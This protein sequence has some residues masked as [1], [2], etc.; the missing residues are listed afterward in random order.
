MRKRYFTE[1]ER[2]AGYKELKKKWNEAR[3]TPN[4][5]A[6]YLVDNYKHQDKIYNRGECTLTPEWIF[7]NILF[8]PCSYC[9]KTG[10]KFIGCNRLD[11]SKP[12]T[13][14]NVEPCCMK[15]N[16]ELIHPKKR[17]DQIIPETGE[18]IKTWESTM[19][20]RRAGFT[21]VTEVCNGKRKQDK[22]YIFRFF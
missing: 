3:H 11:N 21:H 7:E 18:V 2:K 4:G 12:H 6:R 5:R 17:F 9:G 14:D 13:I 15:C 22:G 19:D 10:W 16:V 20:A 1:E 8:K